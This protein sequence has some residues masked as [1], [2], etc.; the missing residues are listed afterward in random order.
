MAGVFGPGALRV[1]RSGRLP[2]DQQGCDRAKAGEEAYKA[3]EERVRAIIHTA[4]SAF[5]A[6]DAD[7]RIVEWNPEAERIFG[8]MRAEVVGRSLSGIVIPVPQRE[9]FERALRKYLETGV[10]PVSTSVEAYALRKDGREFPVELTVAVAGAKENAL[11]HAFVRDTTDRKALDQ[12]REDLTDT[13]VHDLRTPLTSVRG[14]LEL[15]IGGHGGD[16]LPDKQRRLARIAE[17]NCRRLL[18]L[19]N[20]ILDVSRLESGTLKLERAWVSVEE[21]VL[22]AWELQRPIAD[23][24]RLTFVSEA[25]PGLPNAWIDRALLSRVLQN[26]I[27]NAVKFSSE[28]G[29]V[30][31][32]L[33]ADDE[34]AGC[35]RVSVSDTGPGIPEALRGLL[36]Q[37]FVTGGQTGRGS[38]LGL[39]FCRLAVEAHGGRIWVESPKGP[40]ATISLTLPPLAPDLDPSPSPPRT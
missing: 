13:M 36:F 21:L 7:Q 38:G 29:H 39:A 3:S 34:E 25:M 30:L 23:P 12:L 28:G 35:L 33:R 16:A 14:A 20:A 31:V 8:W 40:G 6:V 9:P 27:G 2:C 24:K 5:I 11:F 19:V 18:D 15:L 26:L 1:R 17:V 37:K 10:E 22:E 32:A 4:H